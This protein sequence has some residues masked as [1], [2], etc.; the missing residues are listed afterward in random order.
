MHPRAE[1]WHVSDETLADGLPVATGAVRHLIV[2]QP[3]VPDLIAPDQVSA[4]EDALA[5]IEALAEFLS[6]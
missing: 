4:L 5:E 3:V 2:V 6:A 1:A